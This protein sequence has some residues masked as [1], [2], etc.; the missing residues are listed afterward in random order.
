[1]FWEQFRADALDM[2]GAAIAQVCCSWHTPFVIVRV[3]SDLAGSQSHIDFDE[4][5]DESSI[6][7]AR[8]VK[9]VLPVL[10]IWK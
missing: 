6:K 1:M 9:Q 4:F 8:V 5:V 3:L 2:E 7:A 10:E